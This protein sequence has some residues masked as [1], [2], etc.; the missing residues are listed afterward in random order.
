MRSRKHGDR[1]Y[2]A[3]EAV[4][5][6]LVANRK[7]NAANKLMVDRP[8]SDTVGYLLGSGEWRFVPWLGFIE[9]RAAKEIRGAKG[10]RLVQISRVGY[11]GQLN[12]DWIDVPSGQYVHGCLTKDGAYAVFDAV[13]ALVD[14]PPSD[15]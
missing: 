8:H 4:K 7:Q 11:Q 1:D 6:D 14:Y 15:C 5:S 13:V 9:R 12:A 10:V 2:A 3:L